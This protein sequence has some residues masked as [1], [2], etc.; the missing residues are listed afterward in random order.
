MESPLVL[1]IL[2]KH[3]PTC[4][5]GAVILVRACA[6]QIWEDADLTERQT[7]GYARLTSPLSHLPGPEISKWTSAVYKYHYLNKRAPLYIH[8]LHQKYGP[9]VRV[10]PDHVD[11]CDIK[12]VKEIHKTNGRFLKTNF[13]RKLVSGAVH[14]I[15]ST[16]DPKF[17]AEHRRLLASPISDS[18]LT[19]LEPSIADRVSL[20][21]RRMAEEQDAR[22]A[23]DVF[24]WWLFMT[25]D[26]IG[27]LSFGES[28]GMLESGKKNQYI[29]DLESL[30]SVGAILVTFP[31]LIKIA[32][33]LPLPF[34]KS[35]AEA[36]KRLGMYSAQYVKQYQD[37]ISRNPSEVKPTLFTKL[38]NTEKSGM[39]FSDIR[40]EAQAYIVA[41]SD[42]TAVTLTYLTYHV[43]KN[44]QVKE[45]LLAELA[46]VPEPVTDR[47]L[48]EL[49]YL[50]QV[51]SETL[52][53][54]SAVPAGLPRLVPSEGATFNGFYI[55]G[56][57][58][59]ATQ[60]YSLHRDPAIF[61]DPERFY[62]ERWES[63]T[64]E[65]KDASLPFG[66]G[67]R[68]CLG[69]HL[70]RIELRLAT[71]L[72]YRTFPDARVSTQEGMS[73][74]DMEMAAVFL[75]APKGHRCLIEV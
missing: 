64:K 66:G 43:C 4:L 42:T 2:V 22:G 31:L 54:Y 7:I 26:I 63:P 72:F 75:M 11:I 47:S 67:S 35:T 6:P 53:L 70:A 49:P 10:A 8:A 51:I 19:R 16:I 48:R 74:S 62:P 73:D 38:F 50:S 20:T 60:S 24:K 14:N 21:I 29:F 71:A 41:G 61:P 59:A 46:N 36:G 28:F 55:P 27:E 33:T 3:W 32:R 39:T 57:L 52:R 12:A 15:F 18:S 69:I 5:V 23:I 68:I 58:T 9:I 17:H 65:M 56:G 1:L 34:F 40:Q 45:K 44:R 30:S 13:Y 37:Q 25:T